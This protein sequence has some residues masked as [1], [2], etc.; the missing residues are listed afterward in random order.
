[1]LQQA[2]VALSQKP[3]MIHKDNSMCI[4]QVVTGFIKADRI[5]HVDPYIFSTP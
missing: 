2:R 4:S 5:K 1:M 3:T